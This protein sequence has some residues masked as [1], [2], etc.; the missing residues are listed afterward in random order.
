MP[1]KK[2]GQTHTQTDTLFRDKCSRGPEDITNDEKESKIN[3]DW[4]K[5]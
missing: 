5:M 3:F 2:M 1:I 4:W